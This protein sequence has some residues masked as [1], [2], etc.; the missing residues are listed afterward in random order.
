LKKRSFF[1]KHLLLDI[2]F[3]LLAYS[4]KAESKLGQSHFFLR[5]LTN[6]KKLKNKKANQ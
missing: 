2:D 5:I 1:W 4:E 3:W 6:I